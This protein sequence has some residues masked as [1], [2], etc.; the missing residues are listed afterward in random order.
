MLSW[1][2]ARQPEPAAAA[3]TFMR[4]LKLTLL[5]AAS[6]AVLAGCGGNSGSVPSG[7]VAK[8]GGQTITQEQFNSLIAQAKKQLCGAEARV[9]E[10]RLDGVRDAE[11]PGRRVSR[12]ALRVR[13]RRPSKLGIKVSDKQVADRLTQIKKQYFGGSEARYKKQLKAQG[14][15]D[16]QVTDDIKAQLVS[17]ADLQEGHEQRGRQR[18]GAPEVLQLAP[19]PV[20]DA[21]A[22]RHRAH[23]R[24]EEGA[25]RPALRAGRPRC[26]LRRSSRRST[27]RIRARRTRAAS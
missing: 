7:A 20:R 22:A 10:G 26:E 11:E 14:L 8:C 17:G 18:L 16:Q 4:Y 21:R 2:H 12:P 25:R 23:P 13:R 27:R 1:P 5:L 24:E 9:P 3:F 15:S 6:A 19:E